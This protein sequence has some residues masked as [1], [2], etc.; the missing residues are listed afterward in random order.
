MST[1]EV[2]S[3]IHLDASSNNLDLDSSGNATVNGNMT[4]TQFYGGGGNL[5][6][7][8]VDGI[9]STANATAITIGS[10]ESV[11]IGASFLTLG[12]SNSIEGRIDLMNE[13]STGIGVRLRTN[14]NSYLNGGNVG[15]G[16]GAVTPVSLLHVKSA[17]S[18]T[19]SLITFD[20]SDSAVRGEIKYDDTA[21]I[22]GFQ[23]GTTTQHDIALKTHNTDRLHID[24]LGRVT[25]PSQPAFLAYITNNT[26]QL[27]AG[28]WHN[29]TYFTTELIDKGSNFNHQNGIF[30]APVPR[31]PE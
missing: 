18:A 19:Q 1:L 2:N 13:T 14:G 30:T 8:G 4:A 9:V 12:T 10:D 16:T 26:S 5:T 3:L 21:A 27:A 29:I 25:M 20:R 22:R 24:Y 17:S 23:I 31:Q 7:V 11:T 28:T 15:I 6:G